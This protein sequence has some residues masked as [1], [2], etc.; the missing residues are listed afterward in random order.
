MVNLI[1]IQFEFQH[2]TLNTTDIIKQT[3]NDKKK[4]K[5][6]KRK[7][8]DEDQYEAPPSLKAR[9]VPTWRHKAKS[10]N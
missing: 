9:P 1:L 10:E 3:L 4:I 2:N 5:S 6:M 7:T 8:Q